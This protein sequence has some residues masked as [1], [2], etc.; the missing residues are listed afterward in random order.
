M[1]VCF[2]IVLRSSRY[3]ARAAK[4]IR[5]ILSLIRKVIFSLMPGDFL[6]I[7]WLAREVANFKGRLAFLWNAERNQRERARKEA[8]PHIIS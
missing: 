4:A 6:Q 2:H 3:S 1:A 7:A 5:D 8:D